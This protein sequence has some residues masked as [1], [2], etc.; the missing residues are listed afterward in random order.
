MASND[1]NPDCYQNTRT[2]PQQY[3]GCQTAPA[4]NNVQQPARQYQQ[5]PPVVTTQLQD[6]MS[7]PSQPYTGQGSG[8]DG[9]DKHVWGQSNYG[10]SRETPN[11]AAAEALRSMSNTTYTSNATT[12]V[13]SSSFTPTNAAT[14]RYSTAT[15]QAQQQQQSTTYGSYGQTQP[16]HQNVN[17]NRAQAATMNPAHPS[18]T[19][20]AGYPSQRA[21]AMYSQQRS[22]SPPQPQYTQNTA[23]PVSA[24][25]T[26]AMTGATQYNDCGHRQLPSVD[27]SRNAQTAGVSAS[28]SCGDQ[29]IPAPVAQPT[30]T[31]APDYNQGTITVDPMAVYNPWPD[32]QR[33]QEARRAQ[34]AAEDAARGEEQKAEEAR[35]AEEE[36]KKAEEEQKAREAQVSVA[37]PP[38]QPISKKT[39][40]G[41]TK[42]QKQQATVSESPSTS[43]AGAVQVSVGNPAGLETEIRT[44]MAKMR[45]LNS[46]D[47]MLL[48]RIW[49]E[50]RRAKAP[51]SPTVQNSTPQPAAQPLQVNGPQVA[52]QRKKA[53]PRQD[54]TTTANSK[55]TTQTAVMTQNSVVKLQPPPKPVANS[56]QPAAPPPVRPTGNT[57][58]PPEK[59][60]HLA[61]AAA[62]YLNTLNKDKH[63]TGESI[64]GMLDSNPSYIELCEQLEAMGLKLDRATFAKNLLTAVPDVNSAS[65]QTNPVPNQDTARPSQRPSISGESKVNGIAAQKVRRQSSAVS[66]VS[67]HL[68]KEVSIASPAAP[69]PQSAPAVKSPGF[70]ASYLP[71]PNKSTATS[72]SPAPVAE[73]VSMKPGFKP[74]A[75]KE[76]AARKRNFN[77]LIDLT[78]MSDEDD[79]E[80]PP[81]KK[82]H[83][84]SMHLHGSS[85]TPDDVDHDTAISRVNNFHSPLPQPVSLAGNGPPVP[86]PTSILRD[87]N[88]VQP[89]EKSKALRRN[90]YNIKTIARDVLLAAGRHPEERQLNQHLE[91]LK[92]TLPQVDNSSDLSTL[93]WDIIDP[94][95]PP[96][97]W[98]KDHTL[99]LD[100]EDADDED[101]SDDEGDRAAARPRVLMQQTVGVNGAGNSR[102]QTIPSGTNPFKIKRRGRPPRHSYPITSRPYGYGEDEE[103][104]A[105]SYFAGSSSGQGGGSRAGGPSQYQET[106]R[107]STGSSTVTASEPR[108]S[109]ALVGYSA[110]RGA[111]HNPDGTP[112][113]K[114]RG[115]PVGWRKHIHGSAAA[116]SRTDPN[117]HMN[118]NRFAPNQP[119]TLRN[120]RSGDNEPIVI[121]SRSPSIAGRP[122]RLSTPKYQAFKC[123]WQNCKAELHN[124]ET[125][126]KH[127]HKVHRKHT[128]R[129]TLECLWG[130][131][132]REVTSVDQVTGI[133]IE[134]HA[135]FAFTDEAKWREHLELKHFCPLSWQLGDGP[136]SGLS[137]A[138][139]SASETYLSDAQGRRVTPRVSANPL[140]P[141]GDSSVHGGAS[142]PHPSSTGRGRGRPPRI[143][144]EQE[145]RETL[146]QMVSQKKRVGGPGIDRGGASFVNEKRRKGF[147]DND[148]T[149]EEF[150]DAEE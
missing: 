89:I 127:V 90:E 38:T 122:R 43:T 134:R 72:H 17:N 52:N 34:K 51:K 73:I 99:V 95:E 22:A 132:G 117:G 57:I 4:S 63:L 9:G 148:E 18:L 15:P 37:L 137:D 1:Y 16:R 53:A 14:E 112:I 71:F 102:V 128:L 93:R 131:C 94:G 78:Q 104:N 87:K 125:L 33:Q 35:R 77:D 114:K 6:Y 115:R 67:A 85:G 118:P 56:A 135:P 8:Y 50:E 88:I 124:L 108:S 13:S 120:V 130:D 141:E 98:F 65:R 101:D 111:T 145:A 10:G 136:A 5:A 3:S 75:N 11:R 55:Q 23:V 25:Q 60:V 47:P 82:Q 86:L 133:R 69:S 149:E 12:A 140:R 7:Y 76:E 147:S 64:C 146:R 91:I 126:R 44:M 116:Q 46:K 80:H 139:D 40:S 113:P 97:G 107:R 106:P 144:Q 27:A 29:Q 49:E 54:Q 143:N 81:Q 32:Y 36:R 70:D 74:P 92:Q 142:N 84:G 68:K 58:W 48:A 24:G 62:M 121:D 41:K 109:A 20:V 138:N 42:A 83:V 2:Q 61:N 129:N 110:F 19:T 45:E 30:S 21:Q 100:A 59:K 79:A 150:V 31:N 103:S 123:Q 96:K 39:Q 28:Y 105:G 66:A 119:S 26:V